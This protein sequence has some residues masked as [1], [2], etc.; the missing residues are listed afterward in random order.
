MESARPG[1]EKAWVLTVV[2]QEFLSLLPDQAR[3]DYLAIHVYTTTFESF[4]D[5]VEKYHRTFGLPIV[6]TEFAMQVGYAS[7]APQAQFQYLCE[8]A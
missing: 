5:K 2:T 1:G 7:R 8:T 6:L 3:P 4:R